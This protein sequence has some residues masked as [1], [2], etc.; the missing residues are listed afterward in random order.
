MNISKLE[1]RRSSFLSVEKDFDKIIT[2]LMSNTKLQKLLYYDTKD[3]LNKPNLNDQQLKEIIQNRIKIVPYFQFE[4]KQL[5]YIRISFDQFTPNATNPE[6]RDNVVAFDIFCHPSIWE[7]DN[8]QLRPYK[9]MGEI[10]AMLNRS[11]LTGI[12]QLQFLGANELILN[13]DL[14]GFTMLYSAIHGRIEDK[15]GELERID[16]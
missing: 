8:F 13:K 11:R 3:C 4:D 16:D 7:L 1:D 2:K 14:C 10:D 5:S 6:F 12:G 15:I 9:I